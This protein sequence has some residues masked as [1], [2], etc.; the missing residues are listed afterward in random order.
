MPMA[1]EQLIIIM[2]GGINRNNHDA[3]KVTTFGVS[4]WWRVLGK[5]L[6]LCDL[7]EPRPQPYAG[8]NLILVFQLT[9]GSGDFK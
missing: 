9:I 7:V 3:I 1:L 4:A 2:N 5:V 6:N 8:G